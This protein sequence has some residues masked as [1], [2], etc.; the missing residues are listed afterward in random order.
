MER[1]KSEK[2]VTFGATDN[3]DSTCGGKDCMGEQSRKEPRKSGRT[4]QEDTM[5][6]RA[7]LLTEYI[8]EF[9]TAP[10]NVKKYHC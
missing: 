6:T 9:V 10:I 1:E 2:R 3:K 7:H 8:K 5:S 4:K